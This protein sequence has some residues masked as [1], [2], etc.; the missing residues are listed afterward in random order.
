[1]LSLPFIFLAIFALLM[2]TTYQENYVDYKTFIEKYEKPFVTFKEML[3]RYKNNGK[4][5]FQS[6]N[7]NPI[8]YVNKKY[9]ADWFLFN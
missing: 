7:V 8:D 5:Y 9:R 3:V 1:M 4:D 6:C 2:I